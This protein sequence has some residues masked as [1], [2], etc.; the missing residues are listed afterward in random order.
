MHLHTSTF[1]GFEHES[2]LTGT[3][4]VSLT[5]AVL[6][7]SD[8]SDRTPPG[9]RIQDIG[10]GV[11]VDGA[12][13]AR[14]DILDL[15]SAEIRVVDLSGPLVILGWLYPSGLRSL[16]RGVEN[17][18]EGNLERARAMTFE[19]ALRALQGAGFGPL[20]R[21]TLLRIGFRDLAQDLDLHEDT[22]IRLLLPAG[23]VVRI[24][25][26]YEAATLIART[27][28]STPN[29]ELERT[30]A[31]SYPAHEIMRGRLRDDPSGAQTYYIPFSIPRSVAETRGLLTEVRN[32]LVSLLAHFEPERSRTVSDITGTF[33]ERDSL[34]TFRDNVALPRLERVAPRQSSAPGLREV[35]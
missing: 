11:V 33:G 4:E 18:S 31:D 6:P 34:R 13:P 26:D 12:D 28:R 17:S 15:G 7:Y 19:V 27:G 8:L 35:H 22:A 32:G 24:H 16:R 14:S 30:L 5:R 23:G 29:V 2:P 1:V 10:L 25:M 20:T 9:G 21:P 3:F